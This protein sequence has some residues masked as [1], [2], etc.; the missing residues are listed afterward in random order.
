MLKFSTEELNNTALYYL[1]VR[2][3]YNFLYIAIDV[4]ALSLLRTAVWMYSCALPIQAL[5]KAGRAL[6]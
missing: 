1:A 4:E 6:N 5:L 2:L 3:V